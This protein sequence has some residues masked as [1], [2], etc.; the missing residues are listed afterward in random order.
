MFYFWK[1]LFINAEELLF[2]LFSGFKKT[3][4]IFD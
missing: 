3:I 2:I 1:T 4:F